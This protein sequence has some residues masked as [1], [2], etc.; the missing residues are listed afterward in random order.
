[1]TLAHSTL[2]LTDTSRWQRV[3][4]S[5]FLLDNCAVH[6]RAIPTWRHIALSSDY[7]NGIR[8][9]NI[10][11]GGTPQID[12]THGKPERSGRVAYSCQLN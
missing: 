10:R 6:T 3:D 2:L 5:L 11:K 1:M 8:T 9:G 4:E 7:T 12:D